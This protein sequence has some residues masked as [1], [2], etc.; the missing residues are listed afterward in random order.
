MD[1]FIFCSFPSLTPPPLAAWKKKRDGHDKQVSCLHRDC[2]V[3]VLKWGVGLH[4]Q[5]LVVWVIWF[6]WCVR[7]GKQDKIMRHAWA[8]KKRKRKHRKLHTK[9]A[10]SLPVSLLPPFYSCPST[11]LYT[12]IIDHI[13]QFWVATLKN[14]KNMHMRMSINFAWDWLLTSK[15]NQWHKSI[16]HIQI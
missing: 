3:L 1:H 8:C 10:I 7:C 5:L 12:I 4:L 13:L 2:N 11:P 9:R 6:V 16:N 15:A 14:N